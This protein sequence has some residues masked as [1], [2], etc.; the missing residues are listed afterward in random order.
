MRKPFPIFQSH[1]DLAHS[2]WRRLLKPGDMVIDATCGNG[3]D[4]LM[5]A[6]IALTDDSGLVFAI[7]IQEKAIKNTQAL[8][9]NHLSVSRYNRVH[10][11]QESHEKFPT[12]IEQHSIRLIVYN[13]GY[14]PGTNKTMTTMTNITI[15]S[16][17]EALGKIQ[18]GGAISIACYPGHK[19][20]AIEESA[21]LD[22]ARALDPC[23]WSV[24]HHRWLNR[25]LHPSLILIQKN[26]PF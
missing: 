8:L 13:L 1:L 12:I 7:D 3:H 6:Q 14:L 19:E 9:K 11:I 16:L 21:I 22:W 4:T 20:G 2:Y 10:L 25:N 26:C 24:C 17:K 5:L 15:K 23:T 18:E